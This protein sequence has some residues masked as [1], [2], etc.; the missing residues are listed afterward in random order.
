MIEPDQLKTCKA[1]VLDYFER[2]K[3]ADMV[4]LITILPL[5]TFEIMR[6]TG[7]LLAEGRIRQTGDTLELIT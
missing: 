7:E 2:N 1:Q 4:E 6:S 5:N 3:S